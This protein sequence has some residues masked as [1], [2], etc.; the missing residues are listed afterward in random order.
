MPTINVER[1][2]EIENYSL[3]TILEKAITKRE[4]SE[5]KVESPGGH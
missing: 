1:M 3:T 5:F 4:K 2:L